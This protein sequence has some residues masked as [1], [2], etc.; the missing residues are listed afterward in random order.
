M[1]TVSYRLDW[2]SFEAWPVKLW[3]CE[4]ICVRQ[5]QSLQSGQCR[6][7][8]YKMGCRVWP[9]SKRMQPLQCAQHCQLWQICW[10]HLHT[11]SM[12]QNTR[13]AECCSFSRIQCS[14]SSSQCLSFATRVAYKEAQQAMNL[15]F[16]DTWGSAGRTGQLWSRLDLCKRLSEFCFCVVL[17][18]VIGLSGLSGPSY[19][20]K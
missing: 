12:L 6:E 9:G 3:H 8:A 15:N 17:S 10:R 7:R 1:R 4:I 20:E 16:E 14:L 11:V 2:Q 5:F 13:V 18:G 19:K